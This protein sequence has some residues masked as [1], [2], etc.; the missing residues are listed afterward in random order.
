[1]HDKKGVTLKKIIVSIFIIVLVTIIICIVLTLRAKNKVES[2]DD[3]F[4]AIIESSNAENE[5]NLIPENMKETMEAVVFKVNSSSITV[6]EISDNNE[7]YNVNMGEQGNIGYKKGQEILIYFNGIVTDTYPGSISQVGKIE[8]TKEQTDR[9]IPDEYLE[10]YNTP[11]NNMSV[12]LSQIIATGISFQ[13]N[14]ENE[15][16]FDNPDSYEIFRIETY[17]SGGV[18]ET[19][20]SSIEKIEKNLDVPIEDTMQVTTTALGSKNNSIKYNIDWTPI[21]GELSERR[22]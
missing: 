7:L 9:T 16:T 18:T 22:I 3:N 6:M 15:L 17:N 5:A 8:I 4:V 12:S 10:Y 13:V 2:S 14:S 11:D 21:Y 1:M 20:I 19:G